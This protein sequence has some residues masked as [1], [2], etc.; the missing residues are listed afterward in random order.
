MR[1]IAVATA[2]APRSRISLTNALEL[3]SSMRFAI[4]L[5]VFICLAS[6][7]G[8]IIP[9]NRPDAAYIDQFGPFWFEVLD[10]FSIWGIYNNWWFLADNGVSGG[11][12]QPLSDP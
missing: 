4:S 9:Q 1:L 7:I 10:K 5:L 8:T 2:S 12:H 3:L 11:I 6:L